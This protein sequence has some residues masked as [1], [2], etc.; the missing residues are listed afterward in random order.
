MSDA[1]ILGFV[2]GVVLGTGALIIGLLR[3]RLNE[4]ELP[5]DIDDASVL[6]ESVPDVTCV[7]DTHPGEN[8]VKRL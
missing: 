8:G 3:D 2:G 1:A 7:N 6:D 4:Q 5:R